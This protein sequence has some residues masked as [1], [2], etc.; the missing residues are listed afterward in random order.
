MTPPYIADPDNADTRSQERDNL[1]LDVLS[2]LQIVRRRIP[3]I[4]ALAF[5][6]AVLTAG[7][8]LTLTPIFS[9]SSQVLFDPLVRQ[10][11]DDPNR[12]NRTGQ[13]S[14]VIDSQISVIHS[15]TVLRPVARDNNLVDDPFFGEGR[16]GLFSQLKSLFTGNT[17]K[18]AAT[19]E[20]QE[21][22]TV[23]ALADATVVK[24]VGQTYVISISAESPSPTQAAV[25]ANA[26]AES[27]LSDQK[28][29]AS[30]VSNEAASQIDDRLIDLR[31]RLRQ[32]ESDI[33]K[34][35]A[36][37]KL[38]SSNE[39]LLLTEQELSGVNSRLID[40]R[41][42]LAQATAKYD[43]IQRV[44][45][46]GVDAEAI[47][48]VVNSS[49]ISSLRQQYA[50]AARNEAQLLAELLPSHPSAIRARSQLESLRALIRDEVRRIAESTRIDLQVSQEQVAKLEQQLDSTRGL[51]NVDEAASIKLRELETEA[52]ATRQLYEIAL[53]RAKEISQLEQVVLP[54]ARIISPATPPE[55]PIYPKR[56]IM[57][58][59]AGMLGLVIGTILA[60]SGEALRIA[61]RRL[62]SEFPVMAAPSA[63]LAEPAS[64]P[65][66]LEESA[67]GTAGPA[68][69]LAQLRVSRRTQSLKSRDATPELREVAKLPW[70]SQTDRAG[71][72][73][74][75]SS[76]AISAVQETIERFAA[77]R[78]G[79][80]QRFAREVDRIVT[81]ILKTPVENSARISFLTSPTLGHGQT[82]TAFALALSAAQ[83]DLDVLL[84]D[85]EPKQRML[86]HDLSVDPDE[87]AGP[88]RDR[89]TD[90]E[91]LGISFVSLV[92]GLPK[93]KHHRMNIREAFE[94]ADIARDY[95][96]VIIDGVALP[97]LADDD[98]LVGLSTNFLVT[99]AEREEGQI[100][101]PILAR[102]LLTI[103]GN[104]T[105]GLVRTMTGATS[106]KRRKYA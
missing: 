62:L 58:I 3:L 46:N 21:S 17:Q 6:F 75:L 37:N 80:N 99:V 93:Y 44:L 32:A 35:K 36:D 31:E 98:P 42:A 8:S 20:A 69:K 89:V 79:P 77:G 27:Y 40:A 95:D 76:D 82:V 56:K 12:P 51:S 106:P 70:L 24:R 5:V 30:R 83:R 66:R 49:T 90:Y 61:K 25:L 101:M 43:E 52:Q 63:V 18:D 41:S 105:A 104:R 9:A 84:A 28:R 78:K 39:G 50:Q 45:S 59:L 103:A 73:R 68:S 85:G 74:P 13:S 92:S 55:S 16:P 19:L 102:D 1:A 97:Q 96:L 91:E 94:F 81:D 64:S 53:S 71:N 47:G 11:F 15:D 65:V 100:S 34:F 67:T 60:V 7:Y 26:I 48:D 72:T 23:E 2:I 22:A 86:S 14:E 88:L 87:Q 4:L 38:Q 57:V 54:N 29:Q 33:Q 10:P